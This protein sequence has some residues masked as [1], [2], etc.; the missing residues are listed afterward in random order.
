MNAMPTAAAAGKIDVGGDLTVNRLGFGA[1]RITGSGIWGDPPDRDRAIQALRR[2]VALDVNFI[3]TA[4]SYGPEVSERL[5]AEALYPYP[6]ELVIATKGGLVRPGP[7]RWVPDGRPEHL[8]G[9]CEGS[10][11]RLRLDRIDLYQFHRPDP[12]VPI[13]ESVGALAELK[14]EGKI[15]HIGVS[16]VTEDQ[17]REAERVRAIV[18]V[19]NRYNVVDRSSEPMLDLCDLEM[20][21]FIP[22]APIEETGTIPALMAAARRRGVT[23]RQVALAWL[24]TR[25]PQ[26][27]P[28]PGS[29]DPE[30]VEQNVAAAAIE[31]TA[32]EIR[33]ITL[34]GPEP[35]ITAE[36]V[37]GIVSFRASGLPVVSLYC[38]VDPGA[39]QREVRARVDSLLGQIRPLAK[40]RDLD[41]RSRLSV[42]TDIERIKDAQGSERW[43]PGTIAI[44][45]CSGRDL[46]EEIPLPRRVREQVMVDKTPLA[47][48]MLAVLGEYPRACVLVVN[49]EAAPVWEMYQD[50]MR[51]VRTVTDPLRKA[52]NTGGSRPEDRIQNRVDEQAKRHFRRAA[53]MID[54]LLRTDGYDILVV[55]GHEYELGEFL[56]LL[57]HELRGRVA[58]TFSA[59]PIAT[60]AAEIRSSAQGVM[61]R[62]QHEQDQRLVAHVLELAAAGGLAAVGPEDC[63][64]AGSMSAIDTLLLRD[65]T[66]LAGVVCDESRWLAASGDICP[67]CGKPTRHAP[68]V[69]DELAAAVIDTGGSARQI[70][71]DLMPEEYPVAARLRFPPPPRKAAPRETGDSQ[72]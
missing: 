47:R 1:M 18:S 59:D 70:A 4:D 9:A 25:S 63:L 67:V 65:G 29:G 48:P 3:D 33:A 52:G 44:F 58:G 42:R 24:L 64:R 6:E 60:P 41:H 17:F 28:I 39:S 68:D 30:H 38:R 72:P 15:R 71:A 37:N 5:I 46:Y 20:V 31:L 49:R 66:T 11:R 8:R 21:V 23:E 14:D 54:Q 69:L 10:L 61:R 40:D 7:G 36:T 57:P 13:A 56:R 16:N 53:S 26:V 62:Y 32:G 51:E 2:A 50:Q 12:R 55:G 27:L 22:W 34:G 45:S 19:Q 43:P 35:M